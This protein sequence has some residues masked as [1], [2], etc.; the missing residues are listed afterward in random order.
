MK[1]IG[2]ALGAGAARGLA[3]IGVL[4]ELNAMGIF[5]QII[6]GT[7][8]GALIG[9]WYAAVGSIEEI[10]IEARKKT[11]QEILGLRDISP[12]KVG[13]FFNTARLTEWLRKVTKDPLIE[14][15]KISFAAVATDI[16][17]GE[18]VVLK[19]GKL[20]DAILASIAVPIFF[21]P[22][23]KDGRILVDGGLVEPVPLE[24]CRKLG[25]EFVIGVDLSSDVISE[26]GRTIAA[27]GFWKPWQLFN[28]LDNALS[29]IEHQLVI[30]QRSSE[31]IILTPK[32][33]HIAPTDFSKV[34]AGIKVGIEEVQAWKHE[35]L[36]KA[37]ITH[38]EG[39]FEKIFGFKE[40]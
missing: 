16:L 11:L 8:I 6:A 13:A 30:M 9:G 7:S 19:S 3:H 1:K 34:E 26:A 5:P 27:K 36:R 23:E 4:K 12:R 21:P 38:K 2:L 39:L 24:T 22:V 25:A 20:V 33:G 17:S 18:K 40:E 10:E 35:I 14:D 29:V 31:D 28:V 15:L 32:V 37:G